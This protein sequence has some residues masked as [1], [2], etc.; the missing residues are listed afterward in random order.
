AELAD[1]VGSAFAAGP[2]TYPPG[3][4]AAATAIAVPLSAGGR[5]VAVLALARTV[6]PLRGCPRPFTPADLAAAD[7]LASRAASALENAR[8]YREIQHADRQKNEFL[9]MLAHEL[10][11]PLAPIRNA[12]AILRATGDDPSTL[13]WAGGVI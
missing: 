8:L 11:N 9:S 6:D 4:D 3:L 13:H 2:A 7:A 10:R 12:V 5:R 1:I